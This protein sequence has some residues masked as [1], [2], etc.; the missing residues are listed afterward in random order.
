MKTDISTYGIKYLYW[1]VK[2][3]DKL[4]KKFVTANGFKPLMNEIDKLMIYSPLQYT[5]L[6]SEFEKHFNVAV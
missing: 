6:K 4:R 1:F 2:N 5:F 3:N